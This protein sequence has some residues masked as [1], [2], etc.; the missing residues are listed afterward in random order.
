MRPADWS[1]V[2]L[3]GDPVP[4]DPTTVRNGGNDYVDVA[5]TIRRTAS[6]L[7][8]LSVD[9]AISQAVDALAETASSVADDI[10]KAEAR[11]RETGHALV[12]Y[13]GRLED[14]QS[15]SLEALYRA[16]SARDEAEQ[17][18]STQRRYLSLAGESDDPADALRYEN[19][20]GNASDDGGT[21]RARIHA[22]QD[23][24]RAAQ[25]SR[26]RAAQ[27]AI[28]RIENTTGN[29]GL[30]DSWWDNWGADVLK[31]ITDVAGWVST[32]AGVLALCV[33]WIPVIGQVLA[34]AL[35]LV[36]GIAAV[37]NAIGNIVLASTGERSWTEAVISIVGAALSVVG[38]GAAARLVG[39]AAAAARINGLARM[40][41][42]WA[43][44]VLTVREALR[45]RPSA[46]REA[47][48]AWRM[49]VAAPRNGD[50]AFRLYGGGSGAGGG[51]WSGIDPRT[52]R[53]PRE[54]LGLPDVNNMGTLSVGHVTDASQV[55]HV[56]HALPLDGQP[57]GGA[58]WVFP[59]GSPTNPSVGR[60]TDLD[61]PFMVP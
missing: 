8:S 45:V 42:G 39:S 5:Q 17:A 35:L 6:R 11:Y 2:E 28:D 16:R 61:V 38:L 3:G 37:I 4:G 20:A 48:Q 58:E 9:G 26:D 18:A 53:H 59:G 32:I 10:A 50:D 13:A 36:A 7:R 46:M 57:G 60:V 47:E 49:P 19:L 1:A 15:D 23:Q 40:Q 41:S 14:A 56:R 43:G 29:D 54:T 21:A 44:E 30:K 33:S 55:R 12:S 31:V 22:A 52:L 34:A 25:S 27:A 24:I 51:S